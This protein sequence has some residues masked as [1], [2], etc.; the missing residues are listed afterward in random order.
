MVSVV[1]GPPGPHEKAGV[2]LGCSGSHGL[3]H[4]SNDAWAVPDP[5]QS[6]HCRPRT[7]FK[8][9]L[10]SHTRST[11][12]SHEQAAFL[13]SCFPGIPSSSGSKK[14]NADPA[15]PEDPRAWKVTVSSYWEQESPLTEQ[16]VSPP[17]HKPTRNI[18]RH[19]PKK[20]KWH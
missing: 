20:P 10:D 15:G 16:N 12:L 5:L 3:S 13:L 7:L 14:Q 19:H 6:P 1:P 9:C 17:L 4:P 18:P 2:V 11:L 8:G